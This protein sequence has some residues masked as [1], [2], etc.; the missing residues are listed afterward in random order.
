LHVG[1]EHVV[2]DVVID[3][4]VLSV[5]DRTVELRDCIDTSKAD[6]VRTDGSS[7][8]DPGASTRYVSEA[9]VSELTDGGW[10]VSW[11]RDR[12]SESC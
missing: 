12:R 5:R 1:E 7:A 8:R 3:P 9:L 10:R 4:R 11:S 6:V 2:G